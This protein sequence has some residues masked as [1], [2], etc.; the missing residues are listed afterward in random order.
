MSAEK[1]PVNKKRRLLTWTILLV[2]LVGIST[3][4]YFSATHEPDPDAGL[5]A[6]VA[7]AL[8][9]VGIVVITAAILWMLRSVRKRTRNVQ[10]SRM[11]SLTDWAAKRRWRVRNQEELASRTFP[12][13]AKG[14]RATPRLCIQSIEGEVNGRRISVESW[15]LEHR[16]LGAPISQFVSRPVLRVNA[17]PYLPAVSLGA[18]ESSTTPMFTGPAQMADRKMNTQGALSHVPVQLLRDGMTIQGP[19]FCFGPSDEARRIASLLQRFQRALV[20]LQGWVVT[21]PGE[22]IMTFLEEPAN[23]EI[24]DRRI[25]LAAAIADDLDQYR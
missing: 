2:L 11:A 3:L 5:D 20:G 24:L 10:R 9:L 13:L 15:E 21:S 23:E 1:L 12:D 17:S 16:N 4:S 6:S 18:A 19:F 14:P 22:V 7:W 8:T 25:H